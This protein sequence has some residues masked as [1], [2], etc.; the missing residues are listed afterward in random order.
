MVLREPFQPDLVAPMPACTSLKVSYCA[1]GH[2]A[3]EQ[4]YFHIASSSSFGSLDCVVR[5]VAFSI[6]RRIIH[7]VVEQVPETHRPVLFGLILLLLTLVSRPYSLPT[8]LLLSPFTSDADATSLSVLQFMGI[9]PGSFL[10]LDCA[11][12][13]ARGNLG[14]PHEHVGR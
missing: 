2:V 9:I 6:S 5:K 1:I 8:Y 4:A 3:P 13:L 10:F 11:I 7:R 12:G 14:P